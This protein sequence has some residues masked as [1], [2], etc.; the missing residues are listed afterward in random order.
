MKIAT[1]N[2]NGVRARME[3][4]L[5]W[6]AADRPDV[7]CLQETKAGI[8]QLDG[9]LFLL[10]EYWNYWH[11]SGGYSGVSL[12]LSKA[13]FSEKPRF[14]HPP[15]DH[16][17]RVVEAR[18][19]GLCVISVYVPNGGKDYPAKLR[20]LEALAARIAEL[21][22]RGERVVLCGDLNVARKPIDVY[23]GER[24]DTAIGQRD[25]ER[26]LFE[27]LFT[28]GL[29]DVVRTLRPDDERLYT[30]WPYWRGAREKN[31]GW[32]I[33]YVL[34]SEALAATAA[35]CDVLRHIGT[36]DHAPVVVELP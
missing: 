11:G 13:R 24:K 30:W 26:G 1:W 9:A 4:L 2:V 19:D 22:A 21:H 27:Q 32:R 10:P 3:Q 16:E 29:V 35:S 31:R 36:S 5:A 33:D 14:E 34:A 18:A 25:D 8:D 17:H 23:P 15:F 28:A 6:I 20:F 12:H 7:L